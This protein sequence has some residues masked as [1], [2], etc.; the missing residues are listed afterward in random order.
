M[1]VYEIEIEHK[2]KNVF[3]LGKFRI[4]N[5]CNILIIA[6]TYMY[7]YLTYWNSFCLKVAKA[8]KSLE[9]T[10][11]WKERKTD[12]KVKCAAEGCAGKLYNRRST[13]SEN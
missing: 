6:I 3:C 4:S 13:N 8:S 2:S 12:Q 10:T 9:K 1:S 5:A 7:S 11:T